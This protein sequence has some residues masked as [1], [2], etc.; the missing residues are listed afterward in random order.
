L[1]SVRWTQSNQRNISIAHRPSVEILD[2]YVG[3]KR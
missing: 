2:D 1:L 3:P